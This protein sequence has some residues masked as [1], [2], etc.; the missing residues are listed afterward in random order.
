MKAALLKGESSMRFVTAAVAAIS[1]AASGAAAV[2]APVQLTDA[3]FL[4]AN[5]CLG[6][7][8]SHKL[9]DSDGQAL[10]AL[11]DSQTVGRA[12]YI[13]DRADEMQQDARDAADHAGA[14]QAAHLTAERDGVCHALVATVTTSASR[15]NSS[16]IR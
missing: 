5:R 8:T 2:A 3:Q 6:I 13:S 4:T 11:L 1:L 16:S 9:G 7:A 14:D 15:G 10:K 12:S